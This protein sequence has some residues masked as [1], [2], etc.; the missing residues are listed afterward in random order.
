MLYLYREEVKKAI[1]K[2]RPQKKQER[3]SE[4]EEKA[5]EPE[6]QISEESNFEYDFTLK[7]LDGKTYSLSDFKGKIVLLDFWATWCPPCR[8]AIPYLC[9]I[10]KD[11]KDK[12]LVILGISLD[13]E[14]ED[15]KEFL[16][17][18]EIPYPILLAD[19]NVRRLFEIEAIPT[20]FLF[21]Q[22]G[23]VIYKEVGFAEENM[24]KLRKTIENLTS[25]EG[26]FINYFGNI[27]SFNP[28]HQISST[29]CNNPQECYNTSYNQITDD[30]LQN[31]KNIFTNLRI[32]D[33]P[34][35][36]LLFLIEFFTAFTRETGNGY[37]PIDIIWGEQKSNVFSNAI[38]VVAIMNRLGW[39]VNCFYNY[40]DYYLGINFARGWSITKA[41][42]IVEKGRKYILKEFDTETP[43]GEIKSR[44]GK[45]FKSLGIVVENLKPIPLVRNLPEF[46]GVCAEKEL[47]WWYIDEEFK[48]SVSIPE[49]MLHFTV[50]HP[51]STFG[52][53]FCGIEELKK[54]G[55]AELLR[56]HLEDKD[57]YHQVNF[58]LK[59]CQSED[60]F[61]YDSGADIRSISQQL[62]EGKNDCDGRSV[63]LYS[64]LIGVLDYSSEDVVFLHW[65]FHYALGLKPKTA[66]AESL[67]I[68]RGSYKVDQ[69]YVLDP[70]YTGDTYWGDKIPNLPDECEMIKYYQ[71]ASVDI[72]PGTE[73]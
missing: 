1:E 28:V 55:L 45:K 43:A 14:I 36:Q 51:S 6:E 7:G 15:L 46:G 39:D 60:I 24:E 17:E 62:F 48:M 12:G 49:E 35:A 11:F 8:R 71:T 13:Q 44:G 56:M 27:I 72:K 21:T 70:T 33:N 41:I 2:Y 53:A 54:I 25:Y 5:F 23:R 9:E 30:I 26:V 66:Q 59:F 42:S 47:H 4:K 65:P 52:I 69:Y 19:D 3:I 57:E 32:A 22:D 61:S 58:L 34:Y 38:S 50:N 68:R 40:E 18:N 29:I 16:A 10:Y 73:Y 37:Y 64:L 31:L 67:L 20:L 63:F